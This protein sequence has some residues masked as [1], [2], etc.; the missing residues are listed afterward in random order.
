MVMTQSS[1]VSLEI[2][3]AIMPVTLMVIAGL[4][5]L[6]VLFIMVMQLLAISLETLSV[7]ML[8]VQ[9]MMELKVGL[10]IMKWIIL[11]G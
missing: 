7:T 11:M 9:N 5:D 10:F 3:S 1:A 8:A 6:V 2:L 4:K